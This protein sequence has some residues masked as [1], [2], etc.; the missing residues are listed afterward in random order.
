[1]SR[2]GVTDFLAQAFL[3]HALHVRGANILAVAILSAFRHDHDMVA[4]TCPC[5]RFEAFDHHLLP[6]I[7]IR[8]CC[9]DEHPI[10]AGGQGSIEGEIAT[11]APHHF[12]N[13]RALMT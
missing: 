8:R 4:A 7:Y 11:V 12:D 10:C 6:V 5:P 3:Q 13:E 1:M 2:D 9:W